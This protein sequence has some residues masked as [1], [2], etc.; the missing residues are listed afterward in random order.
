MASRLSGDHR[1]LGTLAS[2]R[3]APGRRRHAYAELSRILLLTASK[4][5][6]HLPGALGEEHVEELSGRRDKKDASRSRGGPRR[7]ALRLGH[8]DDYCAGEPLV[9]L[10]PARI[11]PR[12]SSAQIIIGARRASDWA[13]LRS[14]AP[15][16]PYRHTRAAR[17]SPIPERALATGCRDAPESGCEGAAGLA[18]VQERRGTSRP[19][20]L[21][22]IARRAIHPEVGRLPSRRLGA[23][24]FLVAGGARAGAGHRELRCHPRE[25]CRA[26][27]PRCTR[28]A[29]VVDAE[30]SARRSSTRPGAAP[31]RWSRSPGRPGSVP[32]SRRRVRK[33]WRCLVAGSR[34]V[35]RWA[36]RS[37]SAC[38]SS[39]WPSKP[40]YRGAARLRSAKA[41][42]S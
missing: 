31:G 37:L 42:H 12:S 38:R 10:R 1:A 14:S 41:R 3:R 16:A 34:G 20:R 35:P 26:C 15:R 22:I 11:T 4:L 36:E 30:A 40:S 19:R 23:A 8:R 21:A 17:L 9:E 18:A 29:V 33:R 24:L 28:F 13:G 6:K 32:R 25:F 39:R 27:C 7:D 5:E 2:R